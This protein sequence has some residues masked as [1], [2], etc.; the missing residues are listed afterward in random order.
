VNFAFS[1]EQLALR[2]SMRALA[3]ASAPPAR[4]RA[5]WQTD[6]GRDDSA[7][8]ALGE[9]GVVGLMVPEA[10]GGGG[11][12]ELDLFL[13]LEEL[14][15]AC[16]PDEVVNSCLVAPPLL[17]SAGSDDLRERWL[18]RLAAGDARAAVGLGPSRI[19]A[20]A[21]VSDLVIINLSGRLAAFERD[22][23]T[24]EPLVSMDPSRRL[25]RVTPLY[26]PGKDV[27]PA[28]AAETQA[29]QAVGTASILNGIASRLVEM[30][31]SYVKIRRQFGRPIGSFQGV[32]HQ[33]AHTLSLN[34]LSRNAAMASTWKVA[35]SEPDA[36]DAAPLALL[37][38]VESE[39]ESNRA[40]LQ[41]HGGVGFTWEHD[42]QMWLKRGKAL[43][44]A[45]GGRRHV[46]ETA[47]ASACPIATFTAA[48]RQ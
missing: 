44:Q 21:H 18:P 19:V 5:L 9:I 45:C 28:D 12:D 7:W 10:W 41:L 34:S 48:V 26:A 47:G 37:C 4:L 17:V 14:G 40:A 43:E 11:G 29:R 8:R 36:C 32:K 6:T 13:V 31:T 16:W 46:A 20:D 1:P 25:F 39:A 30:T 35:R 42:L 27:G 38:A 3:R 15:K 22:E 24:L 2:D 23:V 33:L